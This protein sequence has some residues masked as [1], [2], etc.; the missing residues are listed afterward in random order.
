VTG[1]Q[2]CAL[3][4]CSGLDRLAEAILPPM[5]EGMV[6]ELEDVNRSEHGELYVGTR[7]RLASCTGVAFVDESR[8]LATSLVG[9]RMYLIRYDLATGDC[10]VEHEIATTFAGAEVT[11]DLLDFDGRDSILTS[12]CELNSMSRYRLDGAEIRFV[13]DVPIRD[14]AA[15]FCHGA[16][17]SPSG[18]ILCA[19]CIGGGRNVFLI[20]GASGEVLYRF[21]HDDWVP[22][23]TCFVSDERLVV[24]YSRGFP[25]AGPDELVRESKACLVGID[26][27]GGTHTF[28]GEALI[29]DCQA[30]SCVHHEGR[31]FVTDQLSDSVV[32]CA[33]DGDAVTPTAELPGYNFPHGVDFL[34]ELNLLAVTNYGD[35]SIALRPLPGS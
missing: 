17:F 34:P 23:D 8:L 15:G 14:E 9:K 1:V 10:E 6:I 33:I 26:L 3:P 29:P 2:T 18:E 7:K 12:N 25:G 31:V 28:L 16:A 24:V 13:E 27:S 30:E 32:V 35:N 20:S 11:T 5:T 21:A 4:I 22:R 19:T